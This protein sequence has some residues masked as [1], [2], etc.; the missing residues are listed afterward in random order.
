MATALRRPA[1]TASFCAGVYCCQ[2]SPS[3][4]PSLQSSSCSALA[5]LSP[6]ST[7]HT[8]CTHDAATHAQRGRERRRG[9]ITS[10]GTTR[11]TVCVRIVSCNRSHSHSHRPALSSSL[12]VLCEFSTLFCRCAI[13]CASLLL[14]LLSAVCCL[15]LSQYIMYY[16]QDVFWNEMPTTSSILIT[17]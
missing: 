11:G 2:R 4:L 7:A 16:S 8:R 17:A 5:K 3:Q 14:L 10:V 6:E 9:T 13:Q 1:K 12:S 15:L